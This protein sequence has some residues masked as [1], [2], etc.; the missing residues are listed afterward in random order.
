ML[1]EFILKYSPECFLPTLVKINTIL[2]KIIWKYRKPSSFSQLR[3]ISRQ[4]LLRLISSD[5]CSEFS[6]IEDIKKEISD[7]RIKTVSFDIFD[8]LICR[9]LASPSDLFKLIEIEKN[10]KGFSTKRLLAEKIAREN[11]SGEI[12][13]E[14]IYEYMPECFKHY[15]S[16]EL[17]YEKNHCHA[18]ELGKELFDYAKRENKIIIAISDMYLSKRTIQEILLNCGYAIESKCV[19]V[20]SEANQTKRSNGGL[21]QM[22]CKERK[23]ILEEMLHIGD[24][25]ISD[26]I[27]PRLMNIK[28]FHIPNILEEY[29]MKSS[30]LNIAKLYLAKKDLYDSMLFA[31]LSMY[32]LSHKCYQSHWKI[33]GFIMGGTLA[34]SY[35]SFIISTLEKEKVRSLIFVARDG[36]ILKK[37]FDKKLLKIKT[38]YLQA[39][40]RLDL[41]TSDDF[42]ISKER[43]DSKFKAL[44]IAGGGLNLER[45]DLSEL[46]VE[47]TNS[48]KMLIKK[49]QYAYKKYLKSFDIE[50]PAA[51]VDTNTASQS[52]LNL[53]SRFTNVVTSSFYT[54]VVGDQKGTF[55]CFANKLPH[56]QKRI[57]GILTE[58]FLTDTIPSAVGIGENGNIILAN[59]NYNEEIIKEIHHGEMYFNDLSSKETFMNFASLEDWGN[60]VDELLYFT[61]QNELVLWN[62]YIF[63]ND[64][65]EIKIGDLIRLYNEN[66][67]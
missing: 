44:K 23:I 2:K 33:L 18:Y 36:F 28:S 35:V 19:Y 17:E 31:K 24:N 61:T 59:V 48:I 9:D 45:G 22:V 20:S 34:T 32:A 62:E 14:L 40:R 43:L 11:S 25:Y 56:T 26:Y 63:E 65:R 52:A 55:Y 39:N 54:Q 66:R 57:I 47:K 13:I 15:K 6:E 46:T 58:V 5:G 3:G 12:S 29:I 27:T 37:I 8:T 4:K 30:V 51:L 67:I 53:I 42:S 49:N 60:W 10:I 64:N 21:F 1:K 50:S 16:V 7:P 41:A 38:F